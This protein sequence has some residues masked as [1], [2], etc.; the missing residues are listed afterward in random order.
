MKTKSILRTLL[1]LFIGVVIGVL[2]GGR[3]TMHKIHKARDMGTERGFMK[4]VFESFDLKQES[5]DSVKVIMEDFARINHQKH[6]SMQEQ[7]HKLH[8]NLES[9]LS[10]HLSESE[11]KKLRRIMRHRM[12]RPPKGRERINHKQ[13][14]TK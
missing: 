2:A 1:A 4:H 11:L 8:I 6:K 9:D 14:K 3:F 5:K 12:P 13:N 7:M 10:N